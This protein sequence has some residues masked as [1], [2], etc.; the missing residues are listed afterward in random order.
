MIEKIHGAID[1]G[2]QGLQVVVDQNTLAE[3]VEDLILTLICT[4]SSNRDYI[5]LQHWYSNL[6]TWTSFRSINEIPKAINLK[7]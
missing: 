7:F 5:I 3:K 1:T 6:L 4:V 2:I